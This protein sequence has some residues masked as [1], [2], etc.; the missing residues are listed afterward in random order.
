MIF[1]LVGKSLVLGGLP[2]KIEVILVLGMY[3]YIYI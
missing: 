1:V 2:S 3:I